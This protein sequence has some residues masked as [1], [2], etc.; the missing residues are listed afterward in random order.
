[1]NTFDAILTGAGHAE[2]EI[3]KRANGR[4][5]DAVVIGAG[6][7]GSEA[8]LALSRLGAKTLLL[9]MSLDSVCFLAC[10]P[11]IG[12]TSKAQLVRET[13]A[14]GGEIGKT[15]DKAVIQMRMLNGAKGAAVQSLRGQVDKGLY[16][17]I[18]KNTLENQSGLTI[19]QDEVKELLIDGRGAVKGVLT[20]LGITYYCAA[21][22]LASGVY[23]DS[24]IVI[25]EYQKK[26]GPS[27]FF[28]ADGGLSECLKRLGL[29]IRR[30]KTGTPPRADGR[31]VDFS[32]TEIQE[33]ESGICSFSFVNDFYDVPIQSQT[34]CH[35]AYT[36]EKT[37]DIILKN[38]ARSPMY[39]GAISGIGPRYCPSIEDKIM[40]FK[41]KARHQIFIEPEGS[42]TREVYIQG[43]SSSLPTD[44]QIEVIRSITGLEHAEIMRFAYAIEYDCLNPEQ[45]TAALSVKG[46]G[47][48]FTAGQVNG[49]SGYEEAAAQGVVA[50]INA[51]MFLKGREPLVLKRN[52]A[53]IG[54]LIDDLVT[55]GTNEPYRMMTSRAEYR[56]NLRQDNADTR[57]TEKG[58]AVGLVDDERYEKYLKKQAEL[59]KIYELSEQTLP[60]R[61]LKNLFEKKEAAFVYR[62]YGIKEL[63]KR[64]E[65]D[66]SDII[67]LKNEI[68][69]NDVSE[70]ENGGSIPRT[71]E[72]FSG[73][74]SYETPFDGKNGTTENLN[75]NGKNGTAENL[76]PNGKN[77]I[78]ENLNLNDKNGTTENLNLNGKEKMIENS[79][80]NE[81]G[82][83]KNCLEI[84]TALGGFSRAAIKEAEA[85]IKYGGYIG[86]QENE[87]KTFLKADDNTIPDDAD[88]EKMTGLR[89]EAKL[90][91][92]KIRPSS[93][94]QAMRISGVSPADIS[95]LLI[96][97]S[98]KKGS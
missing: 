13:D 59:K 1:M 14:L 45:L 39:N 86:K 69:K 84:L 32:K 2:S 76:N 57:L 42:D 24:R 28:A 12:G 91:L 68:E 77:G 27:G 48:L 98:K 4:T 8:A 23:L 37:R 64:P 18:M 20:A 73:N 44:V 33:G 71:K 79:P 55:K 31:T 40:R 97:L 67:S 38:I 7:A 85:E 63:V 5:F 35:L 30:F 94:G 96:Y 62:G 51:A 41:D 60:P 89:T 92:M 22:V 3:R 78:T 17:R 26:S 72:D 36:T 46:I 93:V 82:A 95:V 43:A 80:L 15:A 34:P 56:L 54:V 52:E 53:Y 81:T 29:E 75:L 61:L 58:R 25:G 65:F 70:G 88:Y 9:T 66:F 6:H 87:I 10:N 16:H 90:K 83:A 49:T 47:G 21:A 11:N 74:V 19:K 50:G